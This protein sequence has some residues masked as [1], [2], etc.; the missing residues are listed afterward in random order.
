MR[1]KEVLA[2]TGLT[3]R[4]VR[5]YI[6]SG[7][8]HPACERSYTGRASFSFDEADVVVLA[9]VAELR[10]AGFAIADIARMQADPGCIPEIILAR[11]AD[12]RTEITQREATLDTLERLDP[13]AVQSCADL[14]AG[15]R[16]TAPS[17]T[18]PKED[19]NMT[20][21]EIKNLLAT[22]MAALLALLAALLCTV[23]LGWLIFNGCFVELTLT[24]GGREMS[25]PYGG[26]TPVLNYGWRPVGETL[27]AWLPVALVLAGAVLFALYI[28]RSRRWMLLAAMSC[29]AVGALATLVLPADIAERVFFQE[30]IGYRFS[31]SYSILPRPHSASTDAFIRA[32]KFIPP[33]AAIGCGVWAL[34]RHRED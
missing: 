32:L 8:V 26:Y 24:P 29:V 7:L 27:F 15:L 6:E 33:L 25:H 3:D 1:M 4:A 14:A 21:H 31:L 22:K 9:E 18:I 17:N 13:T 20:M 19:N 28:A 11:R 5:L 23:N 34:V 10:R 2:R 16:A 30:F 12:L